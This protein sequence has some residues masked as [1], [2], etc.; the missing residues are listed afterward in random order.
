MLSLFATHR[1]TKIKPYFEVSWSYVTR[2]RSYSLETI[3]C[4]GQ[5]TQKLQVGRKKKRN[6]DCLFFMLILYMKFQDPSSSHSRLYANQRQCTDKWTGQTNMPK[7]LQVVHSTFIHI[8]LQSFST[9]DSLGFSSVNKHSVQ[10]SLWVLTETLKIVKILDSWKFSVKSA[11]NIIGI[12][13]KKLEYIFILLVIWSWELQSDCP[14][15]DT[16]R[17]TCTDIMSRIIMKY[18]KNMNRCT[19]YSDVCIFSVHYF[20]I[21]ALY[22][23]V[24]CMLLPLFSFTFGANLEN[25]KC[26]SLTPTFSSLL[27][28]CNEMPTF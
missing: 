10:E 8:D 3:F 17:S 15:V 18:L 4:Q 1:L 6:I 21:K 5:I 12:Q 19:Y 20:M 23:K 2:F 7:K 28:K 25:S 16:D 14:V 24:I 26:L 9:S 13:D 11:L 27:S 22:F